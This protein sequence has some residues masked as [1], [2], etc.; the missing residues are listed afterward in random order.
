MIDPRTLRPL[1]LDTILESVRKTNRAVVVEE[2]WPHGGVGANLAA[3]IQEQAFDHLDAPVQRVTGADV[4]MPYSKRLEQAAI[5]HEE[6]VVSAD[7][8][9]EGASGGPVAD[10]VHAAALRLDGGGN[11][12]EAWMKSV[13]DEVAVGDELVEIETDKANMVYEA[14]IAGTLTEI[15]AEEGGDAADRRGD[16]AGRDDDGR[17]AGH[18]TGAGRAATAEPDGG[19]E[20][21]GAGDAERTGRASAASRRGGSPRHAARPTPATR[22]GGSRPRRWPGG[23]LGS[24]GVDLAGLSGS[25]PGGRIVKADVE[26]AAFRRWGHAGGPASRVAGPAAP[27]AAAAE[28]P[29]TA[30]GSR[31]AIELTRLQQTVARRMA[32]SKATAPHF[33]LTREIDMAAAVEARARIKAA[34]AEGDVVPSFNDMVVKACALALREFPRANGAY[35]DGKFEQYSRINIGIAVAAAGCSGRADGLRRRPQGASSDRRRRREAAERV[36]AGTITPPELS[37][38]TF[39]VSNLGMFGINQLLG[40]NQPAAGRDPRGRLD[41]AGAGR[42]RRCDRPRATG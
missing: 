18:G 12:A 11:G 14:D 25:G 20:L 2:G 32:E 34:A 30:R 40:G 33:Y 38:G 5:P 29:E 9:R 7:W 10:V 27:P 41:R 4:P 22:A 15:L 26:A 35:R 8:R 39:T 24:R 13:G 23:S 42:Q 21:R 28:T 16:R 17:A 1:D 3:L 37:G 19:G 6:H 31:R 36:R